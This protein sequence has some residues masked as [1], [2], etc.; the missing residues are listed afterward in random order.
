[1]AIKFL[2]DRVQKEQD[3]TMSKILELVRKKPY[4]DFETKHLARFTHALFDVSMKRPK[5]EDIKEAV[6]KVAEKKF[7]R[8]KPLPLAPKPHKLAL[9]PTLV[10]MPKPEVIHEPEPLKKMEYIVNT[11]DTPI[12]I[13]IDSV[14]NKPVYKAVE[15]LV[16]KNLVIKVKEA[17]EKDFKKD[18]KILENNEYIKKAVENACKKLKLK[19]EDDMVR[20][21]KYYLKRDLMGF[22]KI[23]VLMQDMKVDAIH[24]DG[25]NRPVTVEVED[26]NL[27][28]NIIFTD[29][30]ELNT[31]LMRLAKATGIELSD[32]NPILNTTFQEFKIQGVKGVGEASSRLNIKKVVP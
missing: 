19:F 14:N 15:P 8:R 22:K 20:K 32:K 9:E 7:P 25:V 23:D 28:T 11:F 5:K 27:E 1:M 10:E 4:P 3:E 6:K 2:L 18:F 17:I 31:L 13:V 24:V 16:N 12:G 29:T 21:V 30:E 26:K